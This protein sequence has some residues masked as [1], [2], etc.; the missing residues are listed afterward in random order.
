MKQTKIAIIGAGSVGST[1]AYSLMLRNIAA[2][3][4][5]IDVDEIRC[6]GEILDL[7]DALSFCR[8]S[9]IQAGTPEKVKDADIIIIAAGARQKPGEDRLSLLEKNKKVISSITQSIKPLNPKSI[10]IVVTNPVDVITFYTQQQLNLPHS[11][12]FGSGT[13]LDTQRLR[14]LL[15]K[16]LHIAEQSI[17]AYMLGEHGDSQFAAW[18]CA[19]VAGIPLTQFGLNEKDLDR[20]DKEARN[21]AYEIISCKG[22]SYYGIAS[23][24]TALCRTII[25]NQKRVTPVSCYL[26]KE[27]LYIS[28]PA[29]LGIDGIE[30]ILNLPLNEKEQRQLKQSIATVKKLID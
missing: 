3:I 6:R 8:P 17:H 13:F 26:E 4:S 11:R 19:R 14:N 18:S 25:F 16:R 27:N 9:S 29:I 23:C 30:R 7:S 22:A 28:L 21:K 20:I 24:V 15:S 10:V 5:L 12:V 1:I 2:E